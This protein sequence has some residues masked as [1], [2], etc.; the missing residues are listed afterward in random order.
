M[1]NKPLT[2]LLEEFLPYQEGLFLSHG[3]PVQQENLWIARRVQWDL[4]K[5]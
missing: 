3:A 2:E 4:L 5:A 1:N